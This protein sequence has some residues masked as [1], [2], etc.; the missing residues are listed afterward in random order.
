[1]YGSAARVDCNPD[2]DGAFEALLVVP[3]HRAHEL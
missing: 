3:R 1:L 2:K